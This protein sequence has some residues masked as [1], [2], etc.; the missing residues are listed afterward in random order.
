MGR[1]WN[2][3]RLAMLRTLWLSGLTAQAIADHL[4][5]VSRSAVLGKI[6][7]LRRESVTVQP[8]GVGELSLARRRHSPKDADPSSAQKTKERRGKSL[9]ELTNASC[10]W[11]IEASAKFAI[12]RIL[13]H[14][15]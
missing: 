8:A 15:P 2:G 9:L 13:S 7:R 12:D 5:G 4:G 3:E 11:L 6:F 10:R 14:F 1:R